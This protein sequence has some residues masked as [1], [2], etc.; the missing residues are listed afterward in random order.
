[1]G[2]S[3]FL[4]TLK[5]FAVIVVAAIL[6]VALENG[7]QIGK[8]SVLMV[9]LLGVLFS[10]VLTASWLQGTVA[11][12]ISV[13]LFNFLFTEPRY[14][15]TIYSSKDII[16]LVFFVITAIVS[17]VVTLR[18]QRQISLA[19][20]NERAAKTLYHIA[21]SF[22]T[23]NGE[24][25]IRQKASAFVQ[26]YV[27]VKSEIQLEGTDTP[28]G[29]HSY[30]IQSSVGEL[31]FIRVYPENSQLSQKDDMIIH[32]VATQ[33]GIAV[34]RERLR[35]EQ[36]NIRFAMEKEQQKSTLLRSVAH[37]LRSPLTALEGESSLLTDNYDILTHEERQLLAGHMREEIQWLTGL[38]EN[39]LNMTRIA[40]NQLLVN[41]EKQPLDDLISEAISHCKRLLKDRK[42][43]LSLPE[44]VVVISV[45]GRLIV[46]V[47][48]N[49]LENAVRHTPERAEIKLSA[50]CNDDCVKIIVADTGAGIPKEMREKI[51]DR[52]VSVQKH[53]V[54]GQ[55][56]LGLG[57]AI[58]KAIMEAHDG[59]IWVEENRPHGAAFIVTLPL[60]V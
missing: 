18:L 46:Q 1:M 59:T 44:D 15:L 47:L 39:I 31:G 40:D 24:D 14:T 21:L 16:L 60:E 42:F 52:F 55:R 4:N 26:D 22:L 12:V 33:V 35:M 27:G 28:F 38:I 36:E 9:F 34:Y 5:T 58:C 49:L 29:E 30:P 13:I 2:K 53:V 54:D 50:N 17:G 23:V 57:L 41:R 10:T 8:E 20:E 32:A 48:V 56:G 6:S 37:D 25:E 19:A 51:F 11:S 45:D 7:Y 43:T 3:V